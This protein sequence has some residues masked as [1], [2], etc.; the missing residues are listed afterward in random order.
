MLSSLFSQKPHEQDQACAFSTTKPHLAAHW[1]MYT[2]PPVRE[3]TK[4]SALL[5]SDS[6]ICRIKRKLVSITLLNKTPAD[7][8]NTPTACYSPGIRTFSQ[9]RVLDFLRSLCPCHSYAQNSLPLADSSNVTFYAKPSSTTLS[10]WS[11]A[12]YVTAVYWTF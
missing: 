7:F 11:W 2:K 1:A 12:H 9:F 4:K 5:S 3:W 8:S 6:P 10:L